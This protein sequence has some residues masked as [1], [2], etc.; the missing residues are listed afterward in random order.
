MEQEPESP[1]RSNAP[2]GVLAL[3]LT[4][5][6][7][8]ACAATGSVEQ[9]GNDV[10]QI[11]EAL[12][13]SA[14][15]R[16]ELSQM[17]VAVVEIQG[18]RPGPISLRA[19]VY[20]VH[21]G[22]QVSEVLEHEFVI[23]LASRLNVVESELSGP[24]A[25]QV[26]VSTLSDVASSYGATHL[27]VGD[28][29]R[30]DGLLIVSVRLI[31]AGSKI[32][33]AAARGTVAF[34]EQ[35]ENET[36]FYGRR[37]PR[38]STAVIPPQLDEPAVMPTQL[39]EPAQPA[40]QAEQSAALDLAQVE[41]DEMPPTAEASGA[42]LVTDPAAAGLSSGSNTVQESRAPITQPV[43]PPTG[44]IE[45]FDTWRKRRQAEQAAEEAGEVESTPSTASTAADLSSASD[46]IRESSA[47][48]TLAAPAQAVPAEDFETWRQRRQV[49]QAA[50][51][52]AEAVDLAKR[53]GIPLDDVFP[54]RKDAR[55]AELLGIPW[56]KHGREQR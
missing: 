27:L 42:N 46:T 15:Q 31:D 23:A 38:V 37:W 7:F 19:A 24:S 1:M 47:P 40:E 29:Q 8:S 22:D 44:G 18:I 16:V 10:Q 26:Q 43:P 4:A 39:D 5:A 13:E 2:A 35:E 9:A 30:C 52:A 12:V 33:V 48:V 55:L 32:I 53:L 28:Y 34:P 11:A 36:W 3:A 20:P 14:R 17:R 49:E 56:P 50:V 54:W 6:L 25:S 45:D 21:H 41:R 51:E